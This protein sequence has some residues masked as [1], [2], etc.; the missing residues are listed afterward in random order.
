MT[1]DQLWRAMARDPYERLELTRIETGSRLGVS[2]VEYVGTNAH[3]WVELKVAKAP[4]D[5]V[6]DHQV[7]LQHPL[8]TEQSIWLI[9]HDRPRIRLVS[10]LLVGLAKGRGWGAFLLVRP[11]V[12]ALVA[13]RRITWRE[14][15]G[16]RSTETLL[17]VTDVLARVN[18]GVPP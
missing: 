14:L 10:W 17:R 18:R 7:R 12:A 15:L 8:T 3:C 9:T 4:G 1:E 11:E 16:H 13:M 5:K 6:L 2:D